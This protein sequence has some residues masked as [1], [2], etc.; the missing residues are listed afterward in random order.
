M[1]IFLLTSLRCG[2]IFSLTAFL[3]TG[4]F[5][6]D[7]QRTCQ[8]VKALKSRNGDLAYQTAKMISRMD[9]K[10]RVTLI[11]PLIE[12]L[13]EDDKRARSSIS[14]A[15]ANI[16][17]KAVPDLMKSLS[18]KDARVREGAAFALEVFGLNSDISPAVP[19]LLHALQDR[20]REVRAA[21]A[22]ALGYTK[23]EATVAPLVNLVKTDEYWLA[24]TNAI[25]SLR[26]LGRRHAK[27]VV[28]ALIEVFKDEEQSWI[29]EGAL[30]F[31]GSDSV[32]PLLEVFQDQTLDR[33]VRLGALRLLAEIGP[34]VMEHPSAMPMLRKVLKHSDESFRMAAIY[35]IGSC[36]AKAKEAIPDLEGIL[37]DKSPFVRMQAAEAL[38]EISPNDRTLSNFVNALIQS[39]KVDKNEIN[40]GPTKS[41]EKRS[42]A[43]NK[44][45]SLG[46]RAKAAIPILIEA[47]H[48]SDIRSMAAGALVS[49]GP[50]ALPALKEASRDKDL[51]VQAAA[52]NAIEKIAARSQGEK[53]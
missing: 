44:L 42:V 8:I 45:V 21:A 5:A 22:S 46:P 35:A 49:I 40:Q 25:N 19:A 18:H 29:V 53:Q 13:K 39:L 51:A 50:D 52:R 20:E 48:D 47:L 15:L 31:Y 26:I 37:T 23:N 24:R 6:D 10:T 3:T 12:A 11:D 2:Y 41:H 30:V 43:L 1:K 14:H 34:G 16:G 38:H 4:A 17:P 9:E 28:P 36:G 33:Y 32:P 7:E 27:Q